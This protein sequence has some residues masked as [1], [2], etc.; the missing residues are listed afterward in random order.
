MAI[1]FSS[2]GETMAITLNHSQV[3]IFASICR[4][5]NNRGATALLEFSNGDV[6]EVE[7]HEIRWA[8]NLVPGEK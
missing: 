4:N 2:Q 3:E 8:R 7:W 1:K 6:K 5:P